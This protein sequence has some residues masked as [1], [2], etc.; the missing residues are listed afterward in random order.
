MTNNTNYSALSMDEIIFLDRNQTY[1]AFDIRKSYPDHIKRAIIGMIT[2]VTTLLSYQQLSAFIHPMKYMV[3]DTSVV[4]NVA[5]VP[6]EKPLQPKPPKI[7][8][9]RGSENVATAA[10]LE[11]KAT[12]HDADTAA[13]AELIDPNEVIS[14]HTTAGDIGPKGTKDGSDVIKQ[15]EPEPVKTQQIVDWTDVMPEYPGGEEALVRTIAGSTEYPEVDKEMNRQGTVVVSF[16]VDENGK[17]TDR[18][19]ARSASSTMDREALRVVGLLKTFKPG[20][21]AGHPVKVRMRL[22]IRYR[23]S[24]E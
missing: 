5:D 20:Q 11:M 14:D 15:A 2:F 16:V 21:Q 17:V 24:S 9:P 18:Q 13:R 22:P 8:P 12:D 3:S 19:I 1:G 6:K 4:V 23:L 7:D 10:L